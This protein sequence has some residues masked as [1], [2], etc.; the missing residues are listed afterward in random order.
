MDRLT[1]KWVLDVGVDAL[2]VWGAAA[3]VFSTLWL[4]PSAIGW[5]GSRLHGRRGGGR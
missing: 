2:Q 3:A 4:L 5:A 1:A